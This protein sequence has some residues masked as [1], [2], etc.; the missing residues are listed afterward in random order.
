M[1]SLSLRHTLCAVHF[2]EGGPFD[3]TTSQGEPVVEEFHYLYI[4]KADG[5]RE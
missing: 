4:I 1:S 5:S 3:I 2:A